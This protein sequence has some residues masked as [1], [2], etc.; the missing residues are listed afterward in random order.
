MV[1]P[2]GQAE[3]RTPAEIRAEIEGQFAFFPPFF[4]PALDSPQ[5]LE[6]LW[7]QTRSAH[8]EGPLPA[9]FKEK[10]F[11]RL[12]RYCAIPYCIISHS[13]ALRPLGMTAQE[14]LALLEQPPLE[15]EGSVEEDLVLITKSPPQTVWP[16]NN[17]ALSL[18]LF[19]CSEFV[20]LSPERAAPHRTEICRL[21][22]PGLYA[23]W[24]ALLSCVKVCHMWVEAHPEISVDI[25]KRTPKNLQPLLHEEPVL[26]DFFRTFPELVK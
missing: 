8:V 4:Q 26:R 25:D 5:V 20:F 21:L 24:T 13:C 11:A 12:S 3:Q 22:A 6:N 16:E 14:V 15:G 2:A 17:S 23:G 10:L 9:L 18:A 7:N 1:S 19:R